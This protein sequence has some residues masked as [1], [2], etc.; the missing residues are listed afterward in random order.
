MN[1][2][3]SLC[4]ATG[5]V[6]GLAVYLVQRRRQRA[7]T[8]ELESLRAAARDSA[9]RIAEMQRYAGE[10]ARHLTNAYAEREALLAD[11]QNLR[12]KLRER[13]NEMDDVPQSD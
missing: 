11:S 2:V 7:M 13:D 8:I 10:Q 6:V 3:L 5:L 12:Q 4:G 1:E 9:V